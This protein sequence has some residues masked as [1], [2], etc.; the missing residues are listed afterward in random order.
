MLLL[1]V[2][3]VLILSTLTINSVYIIMLMILR[4]CTISWLLTVQVYIEDALGDRVWVDLEPCKELITNICT[5][6]ATK[7]YSSVATGGSS[8]AG[9]GKSAEQGKISG[10]TE[11][12]EGSASEV[13]EVTKEGLLSGVETSP[14]YLIVC[15]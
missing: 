13:S 7:P 15:T 3:G 12:S 10:V 6:F 8:G 2:A 5:L 9:G 4:M 11:T 14:R 1:H